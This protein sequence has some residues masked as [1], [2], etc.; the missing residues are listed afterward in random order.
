MRTLT[1]VMIG[2]DTMAVVDIDIEVVFDEGVDV[3]SGDGRGAQKSVKFSIKRSTR[4][5]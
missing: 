1:S 2:D 3:D 4:L 5:K